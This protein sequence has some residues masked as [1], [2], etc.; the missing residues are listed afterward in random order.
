MLGYLFHGGKNGDGIHKLNLFPKEISV[1]KEKIRQIRLGGV[2]M[3]AKS[4][5]IS[6]LSTVDR[7]GESRRTKKKN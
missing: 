2:K 5:L 6:G 4:R 7:S 1:E 3:R